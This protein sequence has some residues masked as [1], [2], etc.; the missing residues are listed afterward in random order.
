MKK[1]TVAFTP[2][3]IHPEL[4]VQ[5]ASL[6]RSPSLLERG[7]GWD[8]VLDVLRQ[9]QVPPG[10]TFTGT[11]DHPGAVV[12]DESNRIVGRFRPILHY[13]GVFPLATVNSYEKPK[14][15]NWQFLAAKTK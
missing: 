10:P 2:S 6:P 5:A 15:F 14:I 13:Q 3:S 1:F 9:Q 11:A 8:E 12:L 4:E 7:H